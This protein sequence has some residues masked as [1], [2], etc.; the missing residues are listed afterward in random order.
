MFAS[1]GVSLVFRASFVR[2]PAE[3][4]HRAHFASLSFALQFN[5]SSESQMVFTALI[6]L[7]KQSWLCTYAY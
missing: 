7:V 2:F 3:T 5:V 4:T 1:F 6:R